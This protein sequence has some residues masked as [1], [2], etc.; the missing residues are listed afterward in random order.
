MKIIDRYF[1]GVQ[2]RD[3]RSF[4]FFL[5]LKFSVFLIKSMKTFSVIEKWLKFTLLIYIN[6][7]LRLLH[8][9]EC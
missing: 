2:S 8:A 4:Q 7:E 9:T 3:E 5:W 6:V 1:Y